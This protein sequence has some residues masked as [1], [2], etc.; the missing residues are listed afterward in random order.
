M[1]LSLYRLCQYLGI[2]PRLWMIPNPI[3]T[4]EYLRVSEPAKL[5][6]SDKILDLGCGNAHWTMLLAEQCAYAVGVEPSKQKIHTARQFIRHSAL[7][8]K[9]EFFATTLQEA[10]L[11]DSAFDHVFSFCVL[12]HIPDL[13]DVL[14]EVHRILKPGGCFHVSVDSLTTIENKN[15]LAKH[16][17]DHSVVQYFTPA[18]LQAQMAV[19]GFRPSAIYPILKSEFARDEF[20]RRIMGGYKRNPYQRMLVRRRFFLEDAQVESDKGIMI[21]GHFERT[22]E[23]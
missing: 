16:K 9:M 1:N 20:S 6:P 8:D 7:K 4:Y 5:S 15:L 12:E 13:H 19:A 11:P 18:S 2:P 22:V 10:H 17:T 23:K 14:L 21:V 3:K